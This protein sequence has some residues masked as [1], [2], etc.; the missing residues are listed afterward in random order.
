MENIINEETVI[1][2]YQFK[3]TSQEKQTQSGVGLLNNCQEQ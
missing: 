3:I 2:D 1:T